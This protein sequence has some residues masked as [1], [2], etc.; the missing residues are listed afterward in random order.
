M[1][2]VWLGDFV[3]KGAVRRTM[4]RVWLGDFLLKGAAHC[5]GCSA[6]H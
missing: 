5:M 6:L 2:R 4:V 1:V 3:R